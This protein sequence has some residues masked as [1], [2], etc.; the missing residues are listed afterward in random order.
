MKALTENFALNDVF[1]IESGVFQS[2]V[3]RVNLLC[4]P[5]MRRIQRA[6]DENCQHNMTV[7]AVSNWGSA[8]LFLT[9]GLRRRVKRSIIENGVFK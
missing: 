4:L 5:D 6:E 3:L 8:I 2:I 1:F 9:Q 7:A